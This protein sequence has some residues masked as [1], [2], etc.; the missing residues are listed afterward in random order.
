MAPND[1]KE[2]IKEELLNITSLN[3]I[4]HSKNI[5]EKILW[6]AIA[7]I[8]SIFIFDVVYTQVQYWEDH[9]SVTSLQ[10][11]KLDDFKLPAV[12][13]CHKG[14][15]KYSIVERL[16][17]Y[18]DPEKNLPVE[19]FKFRNI[20]MKVQVIHEKSRLSPDLT[21]CDSVKDNEKLYVGC[22]VSFPDISQI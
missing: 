19:F 15:Q 1:Q 7:I 2:K 21:P 17:N 13:F 14:L 5:V 11:M 4:S 6:A 22:E 8:G 10:M 20:G 18:I 9:P 16:A 12:T 3:L